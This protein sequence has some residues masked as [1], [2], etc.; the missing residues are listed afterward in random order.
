MRPSFAQHSRAQAG[1]STGNEGDAVNREAQIASVLIIGFTVAVCLDN[2][3]E[4]AAD[5]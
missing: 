5:R 3:F 4:T 1:L 2:P